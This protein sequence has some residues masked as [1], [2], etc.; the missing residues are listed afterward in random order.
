MGA[1]SSWVDCTRRVAAGVFAQ[2]TQR[3]AAATSEP[4]GQRL[5]ALVFTAPLSTHSASLA[6]YKSGHNHNITTDSKFTA[7]QRG[8]SHRR[9]AIHRRVAAAA[10]AKDAALVAVAVCSSGKG[11]GYLCRH[12]LRFAGCR[13]CRLQVVCALK[14]RGADGARVQQH[15]VHAH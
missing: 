9:V 15:A 14:I 8:H 7:K 4:A 1:R 2:Q 13:L 3:L 11:P 10:Q 6:S 12:T 5:P